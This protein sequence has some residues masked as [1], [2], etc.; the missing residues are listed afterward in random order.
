MRLHLT[1]VTGAGN[2][3][4]ALAVGGENPTGRLGSTEEW[5][6]PSNVVKTLTD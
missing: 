5:N 1:N 6:V 4:N 2:N 3:S